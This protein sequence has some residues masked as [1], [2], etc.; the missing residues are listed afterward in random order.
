MSA[1]ATDRAAVRSGTLA[2]RFLAA[3]PLASIY[4]WLS[5]LYAFEAW[6]RV[7]PWLFT[8]ELQ[9][10]QLARSIAATGHPARRGEAYTAGSL[11][12]YATAPFWLINDVAKAYDAIK[13]LD[14]F[15][16]ASVVF[17]TYFLARILVGRKAALLAAAGAGAIPSLAYSSY[18]VDETFAYPW[19]ALCFFLIVKALVTRERWWWAAAVVASA[20]APAMRGELAVIPAALVLAAV[21]AWWSG[22]RAQTWRRSW[23][24]GDWV[25]TVILV[26]GAIF[27]ATSIGSHH[28]DAWQAVTRAYKHR[29]INMLGWA[30]GSLAI[31][32][33]VL[34][35][36]AGLVAL[37]RAPGEVRSREL[38]MF[39]SV[40]LA[41]ILVVALYTAMK[42]A[43]L[44]TTFAT[45][46]EERNLI[47]IVPLL[48][49]GT[50]LVVSRRRISPVGL[51]VAGAYTLYLLVYAL[52]HV[53]QY[54]YQMWIQ[55]YSDALG[56]AILQQGNR[57]LGWTPQFARWLLFAI[58]VVTVLALLAPR[59]LRGRERIGEIVLGAAAVAAVGWSLTGEMAASAGTNALSRQYAA[60]LNKP[61]TWIDDATHLKPTLYMGEAEVDQNPE[62]LLEFWN[63][64]IVRVSS[65]DGSV[66]GPGP[67]GS[68]NLKRNGAL[69]WQD[70]P[71]APTPQYVYGVEDLPCIEFAGAP[72]KSHPFRAGGRY[73]VWR[74]VRLTSPNRFQ[75]VCFGI[76]ADGWTGPN[77][78][79]YYRFSGPA[80]WL[81]VVYSRRDWGYK[82]GA[83]P[84]K[85]TLGHLAIV[86]KQPALVGGI[87]DVNTSVDSTQTKVAW[88]RVPAGAFAVHVGVAKK[89][90]PDDFNHEGDKRQLGVELTYRFFRTRPHG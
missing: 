45:R 79:I 65:L 16:M 48:M 19:A 17:P 70:D 21:F 90:V 35:F 85:I 40:S 77:D 47:Y 72:V 38:R 62:W 8:D 67:S 64:S 14:V 5:G 88:L 23:S 66:L 56:F 59:L 24:A 80:G 1:A 51:A 9:F 75:S 7:T 22:E 89:V 13:Y 3:I 78:S 57:D 82:S 86:D 84:V 44:S 34:P 63:R 42:A 10:T 74:L 31:G 49:V 36:V 37:L 43:F 52:Y 28:S 87:E 61:Y 6:R 68:P 83:T 69:Y 39:R 27:V 73:Q 18:L 50:A 4:V 26:F 55:L 12:S 32:I 53:T 20:L 11:Y 76:Y 54:P 60:T 30:A 58:F 15:V 2:D 71:N 33:G 41:G 29:Q 46:V 81:R 25:G